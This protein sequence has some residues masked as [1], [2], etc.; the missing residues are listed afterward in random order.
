MMSKKICICFG[1]LLSLCLGHYAVVLS[2]SMF[3][4]QDHISGFFKL[5]WGKGGVAW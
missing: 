1:Q 2:L 4:S 5:G 3:M